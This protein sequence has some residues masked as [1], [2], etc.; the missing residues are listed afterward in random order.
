MN[1]NL[2]PPEEKAK[3]PIE[4]RVVGRNAWKEG[5]S[6]GKNNK[7]HNKQK[8]QPQEQPITRTTSSDE[9]ATTNVLN[10]KKPPMSWS[11]PFCWFWVMPSRVRTDLMQPMPFEV[12]TVNDVKAGKVDV[13]EHFQP[14]SK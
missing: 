3:L 6:N 14:G 11:V 13:L 2:I 1:S 9:A 4:F 10:N 12:P 8:E 7:N 5:S